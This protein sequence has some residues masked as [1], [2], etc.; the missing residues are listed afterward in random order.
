MIGIRVYSRYDNFNDAYCFS[1]AFI[2]PW[3][4]VLYTLNMG[5]NLAW[6][7][8]FDEAYVDTNYLNAALGNLDLVHFY[9]FC[10]N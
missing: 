8:M 6:I 4:Y 9:I 5:S 2:S 7:F 10:T 3:V 1:P